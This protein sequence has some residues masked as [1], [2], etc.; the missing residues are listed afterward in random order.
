[1]M[2]VMTGTPGQRM[3]ESST[4][5]EEQVTLPEGCRI[6]TEMR[7]EGAGRTERPATRN[8][9]ASR[10]TPAGAVIVTMATAGGR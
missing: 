5:E 9:S 3:A 4:T 6:E 1:M 7:S 10:T 8:K 2:G